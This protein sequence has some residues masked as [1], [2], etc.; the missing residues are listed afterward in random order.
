[1]ITTL[2]VACAMVMWEPGENAVV[3]D[4]YEE[5]IFSFTALEPE[6]QVCRPAYQVPVTYYVVGVRDEDEGEPSDMLT[7]EWVPDFDVDDD[8]VVGFAD[9]GDFVAAF[10]TTDPRF[11]A[12]GN[13][14]VGFSDFGK[15]VQRFGE[16]NDGQRVV[17][18]A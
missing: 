8:G 13:G 15:F 16:C 2:M 3:H 5:M 11:D 12:D 14:S 17:P 9:F 18:C 1:M 6:M 7:V 4:V 10:G